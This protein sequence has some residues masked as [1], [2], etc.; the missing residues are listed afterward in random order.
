MKRCAFVGLPPET[1]LSDQVLDR[2]AALK[3]FGELEEMG[4]VHLAFYGFTAGAETPQFTGTCN[5]CG[6]CC[7]VLRAIT[8][9]GLEEG[10]QKSNYR[11]VVAPETCVSCG[12]C[13]ERCQVHAITED[14]DGT[15][16][17]D[18]AKCIGCGVC[19]IGCPANAIELAPVSADEWFHVPSSWWEWEERR[20]KYLAE[21]K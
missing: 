18:R 17:V 16:V 21:K 7:A 20:L 2:D 11:A 10:P 15:S 6:D 13:I 9:L 8:N 1:P 14:E 19:V 4:H 12:T 5:C 3:L